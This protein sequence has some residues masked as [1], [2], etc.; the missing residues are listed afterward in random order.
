K[1]VDWALQM[2][3]IQDL[4]E[5]APHELS[6]GQQQRVAIACVLSYATRSYGA[7]RAHIIP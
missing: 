4:R 3:G 2:T 5:R 6:G 7:R 1:R